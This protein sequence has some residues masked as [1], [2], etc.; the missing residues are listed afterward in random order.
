MSNYV[1]SNSD[2]TKYSQDNLTKIMERFAGTEIT[3][4]DAARHLQANGDKLD[5]VSECLWCRVP[6]SHLIDIL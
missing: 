6:S 3:A 1:I 4:T 5:L 2:I